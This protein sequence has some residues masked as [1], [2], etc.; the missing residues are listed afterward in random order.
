LLLLIQESVER[1]VEVG[2]PAFQAFT[3]LEWLVLLA[4]LTATSV[5]LAVGLRLA[6]EVAGRV[7]GSAFPQRRHRRVPLGWSVVT[8]NRR[9]PRPLAGRLALRAP[10]LLL[11]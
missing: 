4:G 6:R 3:P 10:P 11:R 5:L 9:R 1:S 2:H 8:C 7:L